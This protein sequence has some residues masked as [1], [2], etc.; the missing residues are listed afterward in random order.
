MKT[1]CSNN[2]NSEDLYTAAWLCSQ[3]FILTIV[4]DMITPIG[5]TQEMLKY[6]NI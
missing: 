1:Y 2:N 3:I 4:H 6:H 5:L